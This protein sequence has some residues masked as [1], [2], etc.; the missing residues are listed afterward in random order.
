M[1]IMFSLSKAT[2]PSILGF[3]LTDVCIVD[4]VIFL[5]VVIC[6]LGTDI[7]ILADCQSDISVLS[8]YRT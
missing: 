1:H 3:R 7:V 6:W 8:F 5:L 4:F 2:C